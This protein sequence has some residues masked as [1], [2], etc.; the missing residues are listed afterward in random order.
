MSKDAT[1]TPA[2]ELLETIKKSGIPP[3]QIKKFIELVGQKGPWESGRFPNFL[4]SPVFS[5]SLEAAKRGTI[6]KV[7]RTVHCHILGLPQNE[8]ADALQH[9]RYAGTASFSG[10]GK[11]FD[12]HA[13]FKTCKG[14]CTWN[15]FRD[16]ILSAASPI[17]STPAATLAMFDLVKHANDAEIGDELPDT[18]V[19]EDASVFCAYLADMIER[20]KNA[21]E[22][23]LLTNGYANI[24]YVRGTS[25]DEVFSVS[26]DCGAGGRE[27]YVCAFP[28]DDSQ[29]PEG[30]RVLSCNR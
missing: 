21:C 14:L 22:G 4:Q 30:G 8:R 5:D 6:D 3:S 25:A 1:L 18:H 10:S 29:W 15:G 16:R 17:E 7:D 20:Q 13:Y 24:F 2:I 28:L 19:F 26:V 9:L 12:P 27:W 23:V 11:P